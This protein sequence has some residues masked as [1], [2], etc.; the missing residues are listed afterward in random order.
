MSAAG[1]VTGAIKP[2]VRLLPHVTSAVAAEACDFVLAPPVPDATNATNTHAATSR[3]KIDFLIQIPPSLVPPS[4]T[5]FG[6]IGLPRMRARPGPRTDG[7]RRARATACRR[8]S[9]AG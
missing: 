1:P 5:P 9:R 7:T 3:A 4:E 6:V 8:G 2:S